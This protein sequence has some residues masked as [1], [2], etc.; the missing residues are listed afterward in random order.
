MREIYE[1]RVGIVDRER[2]VE[3]R[4][5][6][7]AS[8][9]IVVE[10]HDGQKG[11]RAPSGSGIDGERRGSGRV[12]GVSGLARKEVAEEQGEGG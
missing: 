1:S 5:V 7:G 4:L 9:G 2:N 12:G 3:I 10:T 8:I 6:A 11:A